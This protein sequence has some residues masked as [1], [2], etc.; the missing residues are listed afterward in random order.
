MDKDI[1]KAFFSFGMWHIR[2][3][4]TPHGS[5]YYTAKDEEE[6]FKMLREKRFEFI[7][8]SS[9]SYFFKEF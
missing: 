7:A 1:L 6:M 8:V 3:V 4:Y 5:P 2:S 9:K